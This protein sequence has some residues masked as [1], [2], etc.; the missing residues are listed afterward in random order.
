MIVAGAD[1][2]D[3]RV[4]SR[5]EFLLVSGGNWAS[6]SLA[7]NTRKYHGLLV[8]GG[9]LLLSG[10]DEYLDGKALTPAAYAGGDDDRGLS[11]LHGVSLDP[12]PVFWYRAAGAA[13]KKS[14][15]FD[16]I[17]RVRYEI[18]GEGGLRVAPLIADRGIHEVRTE[19]AIRPEP[20]PGGVRA[21]PLTLRS[22]M[23]FTPAPCL[24]R[25]VIY[26][27]DRE[28]GYAFQEH[29][30]CPGYFSGRG[31]A[32]RL[33]VTADGV[34]PTPSPLPDTK[35]VSWLD[36][37]ADSFLVGDTILA[38]YHWF[39]EPWGRDTFVALPGLL[40]CRGRFEEARA[41]FRWFSRQIRGGLI[42]NRVPGGYTSSDA[43]LWF[44]HALE[45]Y[46]ELSGDDA[47][48]REMRGA[49]EEIVGGYPGS[50]VAHLDGALVTVAPRSTWM[51]TP[52]TPR[53]GKPVEVNALW[54]AALRC[55]ESLGIDTP[56]SADEAQSA[57]SSFWNDDAVCFYDLLD[58]DDPAVRP[59]QVIALA[60]GIPDPSRARRALETV[61]RELL[62]PFGLRTLSPREE[63]Y[64]GRFAGD[65]TYHNGTV[66][67]WLIGPY[68]D[69]LRQYGLSPRTD[70]LLGPL[71]CHLADAGLGTISECFDGDPPHRPA[72]AISQAWSVAEVLRAVLCTP[73]GGDGDGA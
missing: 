45:R 20:L 11:H 10:L 65:R 34:G 29:L 53:A 12:D 57:F 73:S 4:A 32:F 50:A 62:T 61:G 2:R 39:P 28:R 18:E 36:R 56:V 37:A 26:P 17:L 1:L 21:G 22:D 13:M 48:F 52:H 14:I 30:Y 51:D 43:P 59:N 35:P 38:G 49:V 23:P 70:V 64:A 19:Y 25:D 33:E 5:K 47:F 67:P 41:V 27:E 60:L 66:W 46:V 54:I 72:G 3:R 63:G 40:L 9:R 71:L 7:G 58:P 69:A 16:G 42:P 24:Y 44:V 68:I 6:S 31:R 8:A 55:A 15:R